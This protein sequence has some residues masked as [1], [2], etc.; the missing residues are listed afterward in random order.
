VQ[1]R[2]V[3]TLGTKEGASVIVL[4]TKEGAPVARHCRMCSTALVSGLGF[5]NLQAM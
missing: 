2:G 3:G 4:G 1:D 5:F